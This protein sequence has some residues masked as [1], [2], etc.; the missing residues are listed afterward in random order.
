MAPG[1]LLHLATDWQAYAEHMRDVM[2]AAPAWRNQLGPGE[3][4]EKPAWRI[5]THFERRGMNLGHGVWDLLYRR[6]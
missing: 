6:T 2:E 4:S 1:G 3:Y 5:E